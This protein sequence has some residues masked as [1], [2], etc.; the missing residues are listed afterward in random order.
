M[1]DTLAR[2]VLRLAGARFVMLFGVFMGVLVGGQFAILLSR[3]VP[4]EAAAP[5]LVPMAYFSLSIALPLALSSALLVSLGAMNQDGELRALAA[6]GVSH[7]AVVWRLLP[8]IAVGVMICA[9]LTNV[10][11]PHAM[12]DLRANKGRLFQTMIAERVASG[13][14]A[15]DQN[16]STVWVSAVDGSSLRDVHALL[17]RNGSFI[18]AF[19]PR[20][21]WELADDGI[22]VEARDL[23]LLQRDDKGKLMAVDAERWAYV[24]REKEGQQNKIEPDAMST[25]Q[26]WFLAHQRPKPGQSHSIYNDARLT[27]HFRIFL[28]LALAAFCCFAMGMG[29][30]FGTTQNLAGVGI[31][32]VVVA[33]VTWPAFG[34]V[35]SNNQHELMNPGFLLW[36]PAILVWIIG[37]WLCW[38]PQRAREQLTMVMG[39]LAGR[40]A[41]K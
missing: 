16:D 40:R 10:A 33:L 13:E 25:A 19:S 11:L 29:L 14:P 23:T 9:V 37:M 32:V 38:R 22:R 31:V 36:P 35:K 18:A 1:F 27:L 4:P 34:Y 2:Y 17:V 24:L 7:R 20:A 8:L 30:A 39:L 41:K 15:V 12:A 3:G 21:T 26:V 28:P 6:G 5:V